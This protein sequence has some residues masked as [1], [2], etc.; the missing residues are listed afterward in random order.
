MTEQIEEG[1]EARDPDY[2]AYRDAIGKGDHIEFTSDRQADKGPCTG[3]I[4][5]RLDNILCVELG[6]EFL[7]FHLPKLRMYSVTLHQKTKKPLF[8]AD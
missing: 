8:F 1:C 3:I 5:W 6:D 4:H 2:Q 7:H